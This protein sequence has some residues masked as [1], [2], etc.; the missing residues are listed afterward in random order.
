MSH[1]RN[2]HSSYSPPEVP[3]ISHSAYV[4][5]IMWNVITRHHK[6]RWWR[7]LLSRTVMLVK[8]INR[9]RMVCEFQWDIIWTPVKYGP[10][11][12]KLNPFLFFKSCCLYKQLLEDSYPCSSLVL[13]LQA[14][15]NC[16]YNFS[17]LEDLTAAL[18]TFQVFWD[19][20]LC[21]LV[22]SYYRF[23]GIYCLH[24]Q[25][26]RDQDPEIGGRKLGAYCHG[27]GSN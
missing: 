7:R 3:H 8:N 4:T 22:N 19:M 15:S 1:P 20:M 21:R 10:I 9:S 13:A 23:I 16:K 25:G 5:I 14:F 26:T 2:Q 6:A 27:K 18:L 17:R 24:L 11:W 12:W